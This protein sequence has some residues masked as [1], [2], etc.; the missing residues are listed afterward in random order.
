MAVADN[1]AVTKKSSQKVFLNHL[2]LGLVAK[3]FY[4][5]GAL[6]LLL[7]LS[8]VNEAILDSGGVGQ[9]LSAI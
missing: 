9:A 8:F 7:D 1:L 2:W 6:S 3:S 5:I 4:S